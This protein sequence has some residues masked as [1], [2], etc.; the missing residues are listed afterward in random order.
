MAS[1]FPHSPPPPPPGYLV[2][3]SKTKFPGEVQ[4]HLIHLAS[5][6]FWNRAKAQNKQSRTLGSD[7]GDMRSLC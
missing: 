5:T 1:P 7:R 4:P 3:W 6:T 2:D